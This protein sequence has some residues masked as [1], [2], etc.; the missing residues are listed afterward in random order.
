M[1]EE[2][3]S[4]TK[5]LLCILR[6]TIDNRVNE[7]EVYVRDSESRDGNL[8]LKVAPYFVEEFRSI[9]AD[10]FW[11]CCAA[12]RPKTDEF[13]FNDLQNVQLESGVDIEFVWQIVKDILKYDVMVYRWVQVDI[14]DLSCRVIGLEVGMIQGTHQV[15]VVRMDLCHWA[16]SR[17]SQIDGF[18][19]DCK[20]FLRACA[21]LKDGVSLL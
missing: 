18:T 21:S 6:L 14:N 16:I 4:K 1:L 8:D 9:I 3:K 7:I 15:W 13:F 2:L 5:D 11:R 17:N 10:L 12:S 20:I 19:W